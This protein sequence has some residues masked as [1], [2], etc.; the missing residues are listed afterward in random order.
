MTYR[1]LPVLSCLV[2]LLTGCPDDDNLEIT[3]ECEIN[4]LLGFPDGTSAAVQSCAEPTMS[5]SYEI[6]AN[7]PPELRSFE[8]M[9]DTSEHDTVDCWIE[10]KQQG[11]CGTGY[12]DLA[13]PSGELVVATWDCDGV[14]TDNEAEVIFDSGWVQLTSIDTGENTG[15]L[16]GIPTLTTVEGSLDAETSDGV[17]IVGTFRMMIEVTVAEELSDDCFVL[18]SPP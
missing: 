7:A 6:L 4:V 17:S 13:Q 1:V 2:A 9:F 12:Y 11:V 14:L 5:G 15:D 10:I 3:L 8:M 16:T 18:G